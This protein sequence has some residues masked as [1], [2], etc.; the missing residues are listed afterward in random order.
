MTEEIPAAA[1][2]ALPTPGLLL[3]LSCWERRHLC[4]PCSMPSRWKAALPAKAT[5]GIGENMLRAGAARRSTVGVPPPRHA[6]RHRTAV[7]NA[8]RGPAPRPRA[9]H[10]WVTRL[11]ST[12]TRIAPMHRTGVRPYGRR[13][14]AMTTADFITTHSRR[15]RWPSRQHGRATAPSARACS[16][17]F[18][19]PGAPLPG[20]LR[21]TKGGVPRACGERPDETDN[22]EQL[23]LRPLLQHHIVADGDASR[24]RHGRVGAQILVRVGHDRAQ[25]ARVLR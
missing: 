23:R 13:M 16:P 9:S 20:V 22:V 7:T 2:V 8:S 11:C 5:L 19:F 1:R 24:A 14:A 6:P 21:V 3:P 4:R 10:Q 18:V 17:A 25:D 12:T 15:S